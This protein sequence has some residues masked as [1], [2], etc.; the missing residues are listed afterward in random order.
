VSGSH[1]IAAPHAG[2]SGVH[3]GGFGGAHAGAGVGA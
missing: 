1:G 2:G 3:V